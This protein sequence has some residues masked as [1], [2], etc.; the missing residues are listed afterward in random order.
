MALKL[1]ALAS[2]VANVASLA[3]SSVE[4]HASAAA[5]HAARLAAEA[6][7]DAA[8]AVV[9]E[10]QNDIDKLVAELQAA[11]GI[12]ST[13]ITPAV[14]AGPIP[15]IDAPV[16]A[17]VVPPAPVAPVASV[18]PVVPAPAVTPEVPSAPV[19]VSATPDAPVAPVTPAAAPSTV[20]EVHGL[21][22]VSA[23]L[24]HLFPKPKVTTF[25]P[26]DPRNPANS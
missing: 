18:D 24:G 10:A 4:A 8:H 14:A 12:T 25:L 19:A 17:A 20:A 21:A 26:G 13:T 6:A 16:V 11:I 7:R 1:E 5:H 3:K 22:A 2:T 9:V 23:A 15:V